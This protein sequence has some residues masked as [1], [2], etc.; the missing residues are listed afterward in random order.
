MTLTTFFF[1][2]DDTLY[3]PA[4]GLWNAL[5]ERMTIYIHERL[6]IPLEAIPEMRKE[7]FTTY[8]TTLRGLEAIYHIDGRDFLKFV[9]DVPLEKYISPN[10]DLHRILMKIPQQKFIF[11]NADQHH[12]QR[13]L[14]FLNLDD[15]FEGI[16]DIVAVAP[17]CKPEREAF[18][19]AL[20]KAKPCD[21][22]NSVM[23]DDLAANISTAHELG[24]FTIFVGE[25]GTLVN[26]DVKIK[27][28]ND[29]ESL[30]P[31]LI[32]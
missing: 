25:D 5:S 9:H 11:T 12:A 23:I 28:I 26:S 2:L 6:D 27:R 17:Y 7:L 21:A 32:Q 16:I 4:S 19:I 22:H 10:P 8:G 30:L 31:S 13:V 14:K 1:D 15:L 24:F 29:L 3:P 18:E 20:S